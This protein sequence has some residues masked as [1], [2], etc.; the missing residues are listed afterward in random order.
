MKHLTL[1][2]GTN[3]VTVHVFVQFCKAVTHAPVCVLPTGPTR[4]CR[5]Y[6]APSITFVIPGPR[7]VWKVGSVA[8][9]LPPLPVDP[10]WMT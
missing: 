6:V 10:E 4:L 3:H 7:R 1:V 8:R 2:L 5:G 9:W